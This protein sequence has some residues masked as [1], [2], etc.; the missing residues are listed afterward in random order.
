M[1]CTEGLT[2]TCAAALGLPNLISQMIMKY[3]WAANVFGPENTGPNIL[4]DDL[5]RSV[6][7]EL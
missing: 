5:Q 2:A 6:N 1:T 4:V 7:K 3:D